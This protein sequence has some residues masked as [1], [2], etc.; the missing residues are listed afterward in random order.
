MIVRWASCQLKIDSIH[1]RKIHEYLVFSAA[2][3]RKW[4][5]FG[6]DDADRSAYVERLYKVVKDNAKVDRLATFCAYSAGSG[7]DRGRAPHGNARLPNLSART[8]GEPNYVVG[9]GARKLPPIRP[10]WAVGS[11]EWLAEQSRT[12]RRGLGLWCGTSSQ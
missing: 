5:K 12:S 10:E 11:T 4:S 1:D 8:P 3:V 2:S 7:Y 9:D 6:L